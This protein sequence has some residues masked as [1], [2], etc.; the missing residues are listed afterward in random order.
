VA[1]VVEGRGLTK[2]NTDQ[3]N[4]S[5]TQCRTADV[6]SALDRVRQVAVRNKEERF[7]A[8]LH[9]VTIE[10]L[11]AAFLAVKRN[12]SPGVDGV[13]WGTTRQTLS[14]ISG[15]CTRGCNAERTERSLL[16]EYSFRNRMV[17]NGHSASRFS[18]T[19]LSSGP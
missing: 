7:S 14:E 17:A 8:L 16:V 1:E 4:T 2:E 9:H 19:R 3:Q 18:K 13:T 5:R 6:P 11:R 15:I 12:A 10:R